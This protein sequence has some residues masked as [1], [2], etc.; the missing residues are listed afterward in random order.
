MEPPLIR[1]ADP[2]EPAALACLSAY[3]ALLA[4]TVPGE[5]PP[6]LPLPDAATYRPPDGA[7]LLAEAA[8]Q[9][10]GCIALHRHSADTGEL[11]RLWVAPQARGQGLARRLMAAAENRARALGYARLLLDTNEALAPALAL[12][13]STSWAETAPYTSF[14]ATHWFA[15]A[16]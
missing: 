7:F 15:K 10:L 5:T 8:G 11:K 3:F 2:D 1:D 12:Y 9:P 13:R 14:P 6:P 4:E 16:L